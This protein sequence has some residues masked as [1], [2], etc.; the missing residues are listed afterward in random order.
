MKYFFIGNLGAI[1]SVMV[2]AE[3]SPEVTLRERKKART[4]LEISDVATR[5]FAEHGFE[6]VTLSQIAAAAEVSI[7][8]IFNYFGSKEELYFDR[9]G[10]MR[11]SVIATVVE[12][13]AGS[14]VLEA[15]HALLIENMVPFRGSGWGRLDAPD[16]V[17]QLRSF[18][19]TQERSPALRARRLMLGQELGDDLAEVLAR[20]L[21]R[22]PDDPTVLALAAMVGATFELRFDVLRKALDEGLSPRTLRRRV[23]AVVDEAFVRLTAAFGDVD[24]PR[25]K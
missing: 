14:T 7:K 18:F 3:P 17:E 5:L 16:Q 10:E 6:E 24:R 23:V 15:L 20:E 19:R 13:D 4:R 8:T 11:E 22:P 12:R 2:Q 25:A 21:D 1:V 9:V